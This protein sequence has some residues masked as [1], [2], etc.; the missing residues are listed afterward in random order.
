MSISR[1]KKLK[2]ETADVTAANIER[3]AGLFPN[4]ITEIGDGN[5]SVR[6]GIDFDLLRQELSGDYVEGREERYDFTW[7]GKRQAIIE[8]NR[9]IQKTLRP[10]IEESK[11][12]E[13]T[14]N[15]YIE[16]DNLDALKLLQESYLNKV[17]MIYIDPPYNTGN[18]FI[19]NDNFVM[20]RDEYDEETGAV[21]EYGSQMFKNGKDRGRYHSDWC[22]MLYPRLKLAYNLL[23]EDGVIVIH[24]DEHEYVNL[25][26]ILCEIFG[27][28]NNLGTVIWDKRNPKGDAVGIAYQHESIS[29]YCK[30]REIFSSKCILKGPKENAKKMLEKVNQLIQDEGLVNENVRNKYKKWLRQQEFSAGEKAYNLIDENGKIYR[31][32]SMA[33][34]NKNT[35]PDEYF[36]PLIHPVTKKE[37]PIPER[38]WRNPPKTMSE[39]LN[40]GLILFGQD[41]STQPTRKY[42]LEENMY[43]NVS[44]LLYYAGSDDALIAE[45]GLIFDTPKVVSVSKKII[46]P[47]IKENDIILDFFAGSSTTAHAVMQLNAEDGGNRK[48]IMVQLPEAC[49][50]NSAAYKAGYKNISEIGKERI[51]RAGEQIRKEI[52]EE[53]RQSRLGEEPKSVPDI[54]FRVFKIDDTNMKDVYYSAAEYSQETIEGLV[55]NVKEDRTDLDLLYQVLI[56]WGLP[57]DLKHEMEEIDSFTIHIVDTDA[58]IA[59]FEPNIPESVMRKIAEKKPLRAVFRDGSFRSSPGKL[60]IEGIFKT[61]APDTKLRVI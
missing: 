47:I 1:P 13:N 7:V 27:E 34:P 42:L 58:L 19:Y 10:C 31:P 23:S 49:G 53:N 14:E 48:F 2:M 51:R 35:A 25:E 32:V 8:A 60:N 38:G 29:Y 45:L 20:D 3:I 22:S 36:I 12:W 30:N 46:T 28:D 39:L 33:W 54:G 37:C 43:E 50:E 41:E 4:V 61:I 26:K 15:V 44:S 59:C 56:N 6:K 18:D 21:D 40:K 57:L 24:I 5:G 55:D 17:K 11:D 16:G 9:P 52:E